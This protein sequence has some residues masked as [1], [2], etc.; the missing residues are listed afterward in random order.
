M[1]QQS[2]KLS[3]AASHH[4]QSFNFMLQS[5][6]NQ[7]LNHFNPMELHPSDLS[8]DH[9]HPQTKHQVLPFNS[10]KITFSQLRVGQPYRFNDPSALHQEIY[11]QECRLASKTYGAPLI[12]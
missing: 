12:A 10:L 8:H 11:P 2:F 4:I 6:I 7:V 5:G 1:D 3:L 9:S